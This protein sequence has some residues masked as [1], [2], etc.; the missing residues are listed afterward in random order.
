MQKCIDVKVFW[1]LKV[2][3]ILVAF[4]ISGFKLLQSGSSRL[5]LD[6]LHIDTFKPLTVLLIF[7]TLCCTFVYKNN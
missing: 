2:S 3:N 5:I 4:E 6:F 1:K 7:S